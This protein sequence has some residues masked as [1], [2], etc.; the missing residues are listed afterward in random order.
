MN[1]KNIVIFPNAVNENEPQFKIENTKSDL[2][3]FGWLGG[4]SHLHDLQ[5]LDQSFSKLSSYN[6]KLQYVLCGFDTRGTMTEINK[7]T[8]EQRQRPIRPEETVWVKYEEFFTDKYK[9][10]TPDYKKFLDLLSKYEQK[11][12]SDDDSLYLL[13][14][15]TNIY[16]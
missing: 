1:I 16:L 2:V 9:I 7:E 11:P 5:L 10:V 3:R 8:G 4:S 12:T 14:I 15:N 13:K 6:D